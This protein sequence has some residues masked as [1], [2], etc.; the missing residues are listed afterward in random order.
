[1]TSSSDVYMDMI[2]PGKTQV[3]IIN[4]TA[5]P[6][7]SRSAILNVSLTFSFSPAPQYWAARTLEPPMIPMHRIVKKL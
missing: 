3:R 6:A 4:S 2:G 7:E 1:M 5:T